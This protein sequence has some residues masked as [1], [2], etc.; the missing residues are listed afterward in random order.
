M[1]TYLVLIIDRATGKAMMEFQIEAIEYPVKIT[2]EYHAKRQAAMEFREL[3]RYTPRLRKVTDWH[4]DV[5][6][7]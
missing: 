2:E 4:V 5:L 7:I 1:A 3:Q 6:A